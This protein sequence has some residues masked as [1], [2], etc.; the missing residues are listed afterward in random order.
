MSHRPG[1][2]RTKRMHYSVS[3]IS[4]RVGMQTGDRMTARAQQRGSTVCRKSPVFHRQERKGDSNSA[5]GRLSANCRP[6]ESPRCLPHILCR[7]VSVVC[8]KEVSSYFRLTDPTSLVHQMDVIRCFLCM[9]I[10]SGY[11]I[12]SPTQIM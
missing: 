12:L 3:N 1:R 5:D 4:C 2:M 9:F 7:S 11:R 8:A 10:D 6:C